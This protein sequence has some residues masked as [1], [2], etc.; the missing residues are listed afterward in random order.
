MKIKFEL[1]KSKI[2][3]IEYYG[4]LI[5]SSEEDSIKIDITVRKNND[6]LF[7]CYPSKKSTKDNKYYAT[8]FLS[9]DL[10]KKVN[11]ALNKKYNNDL[12]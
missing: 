7:V 2:E 10:Y 4:E 11:K 6:E 9:D 12:D 1:E 3:G 8:T 5:L